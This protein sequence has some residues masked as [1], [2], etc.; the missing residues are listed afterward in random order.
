MTWNK[1]AIGGLGPALTAIALGL[2]AK[3]QWGMGEA[4]W[5]AVGVVV[6]GLLTYFIPNKET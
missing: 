5:G 6:F 1:A 3:F 2:D 4:F